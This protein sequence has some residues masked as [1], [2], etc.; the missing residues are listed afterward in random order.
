MATPG[1]TTL[2]SINAIRGKEANHKKTPETSPKRATTE[3]ARNSSYTTM[4]HAGTTNKGRKDETNDMEF[5]EGETSPLRGL[6]L[7]KKFQER[8]SYGQPL[9]LEGLQLVATGNF[10][11]NAGR[12]E[13]QLGPT[14]HLYMGNNALK[15]LITSHGGKYI[16]SI[17]NKLTSSSL[18]A[19]QTRSRLKK[20][21]EPRPN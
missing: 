12:S 3:E 11:E 15:R 14:S 1:G 19:N 17:I 2:S 8:G 9:A 7:N 18:A 10:P 16:S 20:L 6:G 21:K 13:L 4:P 5:K